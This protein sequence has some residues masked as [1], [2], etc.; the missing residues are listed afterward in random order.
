MSKDRSE[1]RS[2]AN[3]AKSSVRSDDIVSSRLS[4]ASEKRRFVP[5]LAHLGVLDSELKVPGDPKGV[6]GVP[7]CRTQSHQLH[8]KVAFELQPD[9]TGVRQPNSDGIQSSSWAH[10][11]RNIVTW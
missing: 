11:R 1:E 6:S 10:E 3:E 7:L 4:V 9:G 2:E 5:P 8:S